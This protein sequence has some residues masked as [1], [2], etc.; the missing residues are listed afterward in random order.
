MNTFDPTTHQYFIDGQPV[1][2]VT[3]VLQLEGCYKNSEWFTEEGRILGSRIHKV[4]ERYD[5]GGLDES[6]VDPEMEGYLASWKKY[7][8][9]TGFLPFLIE[10]SIFSIHRRLAG[11]PDRAGVDRSGEIWIIDLKRGAK[12]EASALQTAAYNILIFDSDHAQKVAEKGR[13][14]RAAVHLDEEGGYPKV[15]EHTERTDI[16]VFSSFLMGV[17]WKKSKGLV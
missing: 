9:E 12:Q 17:Q 5:R 3:Q 6:T 11:T 13:I 7:R 2:S 10:E 1:L 8:K 4:C 15:Y 16:P 14:R